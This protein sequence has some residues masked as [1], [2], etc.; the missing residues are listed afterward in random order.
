M[1]GDVNRVCKRVPHP[2]SNGSTTAE[3]QR[4]VSANLVRAQVTDNAE[5]TYRH[6]DA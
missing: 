4:A 1:E 5:Q 3:V 6:E 2:A